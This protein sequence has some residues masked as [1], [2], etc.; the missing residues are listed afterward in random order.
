MKVLNKLALMFVFVASS[1]VV[2]VNAQTI[3]GEVPNVVLEKEVQSK[4]LRLPYYEVFDF[5]SFRID[6]DTVILDGKVRNATNRR[7]AE[8]AV[9]R[10]S[11]VEKVQNNIE[12]LNV[13]G[14]DDRIRRDLYGS[15][16]RTGSLSRYLWTVN[17]SMRLVV[18]RGHVT[19]EG[20]VA[21][22]GD[23]NLANIAARSVP[24]VF[25]VTNNLK[26]DSKRAG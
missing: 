18:D 14:F 22:E 6:G 4:I 8:A 17:P 2:G 7:E 16:A 5:I 11:G 24:G 1:T 20:Y 21:N 10:I 9:K 15:L 13:G 23:L 19:L 3:T 25:S 12:I 26:V